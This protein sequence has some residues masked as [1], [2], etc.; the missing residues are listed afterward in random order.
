MTVMM[1][2]RERMIYKCLAAAFVI[3]SQRKKIPRCA[4][5]AA[6]RFWLW[7]DRRE[8]IPPQTLFAC[9]FATDERRQQPPPPQAKHAKRN[10]RMV[11]YIVSVR[12]CLRAAATSR[13]IA[14][15]FA[16]FFRVSME[17]PIPRAQTKDKVKV[18]FLSS[19]GACPSEG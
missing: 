16:P 7:C 8:C 17:T 11:G 13:A 14:S 6:V 5:C 2:M 9:P 19:V 1:I 12:A 3:V 15:S 4:L 18:T 10:Q